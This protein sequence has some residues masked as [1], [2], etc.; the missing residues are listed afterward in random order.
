[1][2]GGKGSLSGEHHMEPRPGPSHGQEDPPS[3]LPPRHC[4]SCRKP[5]EGPERRFVYT[6][7]TAASFATAERWGQPTCPSAEEWISQMQSSN[8][9]EHHSALKK[10]EVL[11]YVRGMDEP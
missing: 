3:P 4:P 11:L 1:M 5:G 9:M 7:F 10:K 6:A 2:A 8:K